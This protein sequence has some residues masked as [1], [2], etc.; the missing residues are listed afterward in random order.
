MA[1][2]TLQKIIQL[3]NEL[4]QAEQ[5]EHEKI[6]AWVQKQQEEIEQNHADQLENLELNR[7]TFRER[8]IADA[9]AKSK[10]IINESKEKANCLDNINDSF[11]KKS[12]QKLIPLI[13][14]HGS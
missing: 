5:M 4:Y 14:G 8:T 7:T 1:I 2:Q 6:S 13:S 11:L 3:E 9:Q 12:L 10:N